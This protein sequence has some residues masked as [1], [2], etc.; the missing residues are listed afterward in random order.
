MQPVKEF[1]VQSV[2]LQLLKV[3][4]LAQLSGDRAYEVVIAQAQLLQH[5]LMSWPTRPDSNSP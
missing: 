1:P 5:G 3:G 4:K 2:R